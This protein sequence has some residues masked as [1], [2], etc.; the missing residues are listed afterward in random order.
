MHLHEAVIEAT[1][2]ENLGR[3][4]VAVR[5]YLKVIVEKLHLRTL[6][7]ILQN[8]T[9]RELLAWYKKLNNFGCP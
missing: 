3:A 1:N 6:I 5:I 4:K 9:A 8:P 2:V 7:F